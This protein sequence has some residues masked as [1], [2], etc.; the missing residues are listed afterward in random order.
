MTNAN[1]SL[2]HYTGTESYYRDLLTGHLYTDGVRELATANGAYWLLDIVFSH[3]LNKKV[4]SEPFQVWELKRVSGIMFNVVA[5]DGNNNQIAQQEIP[6]SDFK[7]DLA[8]IWM[9]HGVALLPSEH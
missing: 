2:R 6:F 1:E 4:K 3:Q 9:E 5:T 7:F 8:T